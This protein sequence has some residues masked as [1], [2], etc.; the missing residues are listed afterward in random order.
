MSLFD[1]ILHRFNKETNLSLCISPVIDTFFL[2]LFD[3][4]VI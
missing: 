4:R 3:G 2:V 1:V